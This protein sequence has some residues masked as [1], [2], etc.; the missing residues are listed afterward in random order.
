MANTKSAER[1]TRSNARKR[2]RNR[3]VKTKLRTAE[4]K[5]RASLTTGTTDDRAKLYREYV[6]AFD[7]AAKSGVV[8]K[9]TAD[10]KKSRLA[11]SVNK[12][13]AAK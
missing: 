2:L 7:R 11:I 3:E 4:K 6:S 5:L 12:A 13:N 9:G 1:R 10:R 8:H